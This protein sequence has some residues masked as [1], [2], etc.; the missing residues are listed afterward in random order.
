MYDKLKNTGILTK[1]ARI[2][3]NLWY[4]ISLLFCVLAIKRDKQQQ[5]REQQQHCFMSA[6]F[7]I[8]LILEY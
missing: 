2:H 6:I 3:Y 4:R 1:Y 8:E 7:L 5:K